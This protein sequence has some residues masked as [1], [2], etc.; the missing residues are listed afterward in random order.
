MVHWPTLTEERRLW[1]QGYRLIAGVDE[2]G[3]G[4]LAGPVG[5]AAVILP[6]GKLSLDG[7][8]DSKELTA[9]Q[10]Q[11]LAKQIQNQALAV[12]VA[13]VPAEVVDELGI[14]EATRRAMC[15]AI[16]SL[17]PSPHHLLI[18]AL[19]LPLALPQKAIINGD[20]LCLSIACASIV[21]KVARDRLMEEMDGL[22][23]GYGF[24]SHKGYG[25]RQH[26]LGLERLGACAIHRRS[27]APVRVVCLENRVEQ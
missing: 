16:A 20:R 6:R 7:V 11:R 27:F 5:A 19:R 1:Q 15:S 12:G 17:S 22:Y 3:R 25:T 10:R 14:V 23:P 26:L 18:D 13:M 9:A 8:R 4:S 2:V 21:A 24:A